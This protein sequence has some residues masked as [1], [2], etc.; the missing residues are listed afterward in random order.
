ML[1]VVGLLCFA[2]RSEKSR[3][4][5]A[6]RRTLEADE[7]SALIVRGSADGIILTDQ[8]GRIQMT[9]PSLHAMFQTDEEQLRGQPLTS[10]FATTAVD[11]WLTHRWDEESRPS[12]RRTVVAT[13][14]DGSTLPVELAI[15]TSRLHH[16]D[17]LAISVRDISEREAIRLRF[18]QHEALLSEIPDPLHIL[19]AAGRIVFW[20]QGAQRLFGFESSDA[21]GQ[22]AHDLLGI[23]PPQG[24][25]T[26]IH[27]VE[28]AAA[29]RWMGELRAKTKDGRWLN[30]E[31]RRTRIME[32]NESIGEVIFDL[33]L[34]QRDRLQQ[35]DAAA[36]ALNRSARWPAESRMT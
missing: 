33:D 3:R 11:E 4:A 16:Q 24:N 21:L 27:A 26:N 8:T 6:D 19:D 23:V 7:R 22:S 10:L 5:L 34:G 25:L 32:K 17:F 36:N 31:R 2:H 14:A 12:L 29:Q 28:Y 30:I 15:T 18:K 35:V 1:V 13:R 9:N 20:N